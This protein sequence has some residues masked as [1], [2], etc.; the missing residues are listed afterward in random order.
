MKTV[1]CLR[2]ASHWMGH[3][4]LLF[5]RLMF[6]SSIMMKIASFQDLPEEI[7]FSSP[8]ELKLFRYPLRATLYVSASCRHKQPRN[9]NGKGTVVISLCF[10]FFVNFADLA[11]CAMEISFINDCFPR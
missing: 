11:A 5:Q 8:F 9:V 7:D 6:T 2:V 1:T 3:L 4:S 10:C